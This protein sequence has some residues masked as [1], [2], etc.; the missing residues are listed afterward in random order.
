LKGE[1][2]NCD[3]GC[4]NDL[5]DWW[6]KN[7]T[8][9]SIAGV[10]F[11]GNPTMVFG[12]M[13]TRGE[14]P[15]GLSEI[16]GGGTFYRFDVAGG[17]AK[18]RFAVDDEP[19]TR[20]RLVVGIVHEMGHA[21]WLEHLPFVGEGSYSQTMTRTLRDAAWANDNIP[22]FKYDGIEGFLIAPDGKSGKN[23]SS[24][25]G[26]EESSWLSTL[27]YPATMRITD[28]FIARHHYLKLM[29]TWGREQ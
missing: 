10:D 22:A 6:E 1:A 28:F 20:G 23:K 29:R 3:T 15:A 27:M 24:T 19:A 7:P 18:A 14:G 9:S 2:Q 4:A 16:V 17:P 11:S 21:L 5:I 25:E 26:N 8:A 13:P 12:I